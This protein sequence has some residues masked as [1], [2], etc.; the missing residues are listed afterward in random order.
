MWKY[1][2]KLMV[3][4][5]STVVVDGFRRAFVD[6]LTQAGGRGVLDGLG[7]NE[8][9][10]CEREPF[11]EY[12]TRWVKGEDLVFR[13]EVVSVVVDEAARSAALAED[14]RAERDR[15]LVR[16]DWTQLVDS[17]LD[18]E[19]MVLW[20]GYRQALRDVPQQPEFPVAVAWPEPPVME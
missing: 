5:P 17:A 18:A 10:P 11:T 1:E 12:E 6:V 16:S 15:M 3:N 4:P 20:Q 9:V 2:Q 7:Y 14:V 8:A 13:E 19:A